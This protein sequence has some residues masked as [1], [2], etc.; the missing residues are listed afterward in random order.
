MRACQILMLMA[1]LPIVGLCGSCL[2]KDAG[3]MHN[4]CGTFN[5]CDDGLEQRFDSNNFCVC[6][7]PC[8]RDKDCPK[9]MFCRTKKPKGQLANI[10]VEKVEPE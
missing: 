10:C 9:H 2:V 8:K 6:E 4:V 3:K 1:L 7:M 5:A